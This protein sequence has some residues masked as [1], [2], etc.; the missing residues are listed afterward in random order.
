MTKTGK[1]LTKQ[2]CVVKVV[3]GSCTV[4]KGHKLV[5]KGKQLQNV[6]FVSKTV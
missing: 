2:D 6:W 3:T 5:A 1:K 4:G